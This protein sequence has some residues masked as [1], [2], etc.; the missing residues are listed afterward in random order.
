MMTFNKNT[1]KYTNNLTEKQ[2]KDIKSSSYSK[3]K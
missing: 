1:E 3:Y 2:V